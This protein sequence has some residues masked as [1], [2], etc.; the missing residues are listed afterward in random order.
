ME[1]NTA[2]EA[3]QPA[4]DPQ[5]AR[6]WA[7][8]NDDAL[9]EMAVGLAEQ[10]AGLFR[11]ARAAKVALY[12]RLVDRKATVLDT[13]HWT[14][15]MKPGPIHHAIDDIRRFCQRLAPLVDPEDLAKAFIQDPQ[16]PVPALR[17]DHRGINELDK[18]GGQV[19]EI[20]KE[21]RTSQRG[22]P[23]LELKRKPTVD[24]ERAEQEGP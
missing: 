18:R 6:P 14:G 24:E 22:N 17:E 9:A 2:A 5:L 8:Y 11:K 1:G 12:G 10:A 15:K 3:R 7:D 13:P 21:E 19:S 4:G 16:P 23:I 20:I